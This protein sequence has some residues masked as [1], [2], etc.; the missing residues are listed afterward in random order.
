MYIIAFTSGWSRADSD[1]D[2]VAAIR[3]RG[4]TYKTV[5]PNRPGDDY[6]K[7]KGD[8]WKLNLRSQFRISGCVKPANVNYIAI[9]EGGNDAWNIESIVTVFH[10]SQY[11]NELA[12]ADFDIYQWIDG[13]GSDSHRHY[14]LTKMY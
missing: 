5:L 9:E 2:H 14:E 1:S 6:Q 4:T 13:D 12:T 10:Y 8:L 7:H 11:N 3:V